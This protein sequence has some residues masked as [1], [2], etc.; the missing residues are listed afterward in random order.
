MAAILDYL[1]TLH[2]FVVIE[3]GEKGYCIMTDSKIYASSQFR[4][5]CL[6]SVLISRSII[7][8]MYW[9][10]RHDVIK[11][12]QTIITKRCFIKCI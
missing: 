11:Q 2:E 7:K 3:W 10:W 4:M 1:I 8:L 12:Q 9:I 5:K 6:C